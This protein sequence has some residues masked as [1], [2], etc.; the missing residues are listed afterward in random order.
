M[1]GTRRMM[2]S[3]AIMC[4]VMLGFVQ[5]ERMESHYESIVLQWLKKTPRID[6]HDMSLPGSTSFILSFIFSVLIFLNSFTL[7]MIH[8][9]PDLAHRIVSSGGWPCYATLVELHLHTTQYS[10]HSEDESTPV[11]GV[12]QSIIDEVTRICLNGDHGAYEIASRQQTPPLSEQQIIF[13]RQHNGLGNQLFQ[14]IFSRLLAVGTH[15]AFQTSLLVPEN[16]EAP[17]KKIEYPP[18]S[19]SGWSLFQILFRADESYPS[20]IPGNV[21]VCL[22]DSKRC[23]IRCLSY[24]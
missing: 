2:K 3:L 8:S 13:N 17:W 10:R 19:V 5:G 15:R 18:N 24:P 23:V 9:L 7:P 21:S 20:H 16:G 22:D 14:Y 6:F 1:V 11:I 12:A 4:I